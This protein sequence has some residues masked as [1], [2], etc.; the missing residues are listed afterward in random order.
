MECIGLAFMKVEDYETQT[1]ATPSVFISE[2]I[3]KAGMVQPLSALNQPVASLDKPLN[4]KVKGLVIETDMGD[5]TIKLYN[6]TP[7]YRDNFVKLVREGYYNDLLVHRVIKDFCIQS[8]AA[9]TR[10]AEPDDVVGWK[11]PGYSLPAHFVP[12]LYHK[13]GV[14]G[15]PRKPDTDNSRKR[16]DGS[17]FYIVTGRI[18]TDAEL[19]DFEK[20]SGYKYTEEQRNVYKTIGGA[21][22]LD[23]SY[24][25]FGEVVN[26]MDV[27]DRISIVEVKSDMRPKKDIRVK[28]IRILE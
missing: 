6:S 21:P 9:D 25:I 12:G 3:K 11:G 18:Y 17:Q 28:K 27:A 13:R 14:V 5:I 26:G 24:T 1:F 8:G 10:L 7:Q 19:D 4:T 22:H 20:E 16:S 23:G 2:L 15:S